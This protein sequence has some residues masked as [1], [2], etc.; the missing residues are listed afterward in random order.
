MVQ[1]LDIRPTWQKILIVICAEFPGWEFELLPSLSRLEQ[2]NPPNQFFATEEQ[3]ERL[4]EVPV[5]TGCV[6]NPP[7]Q[8]G[9]EHVNDGEQNVAAPPPNHKWIW[10][11]FSDGVVLMVNSFVY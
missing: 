4:M 7:E 8:L 2:P 9:E 1:H 6:D 10:Q 3:E 11:N 5:Q